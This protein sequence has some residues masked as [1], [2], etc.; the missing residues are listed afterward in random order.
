MGPADQHSV[1][2]VE[3]RPGELSFRARI[4]GLDK[5]LFVRST[6]TDLTPN[7][8]AA[9]AGCLMPA[10]APGGTLT[11]D[12]EVSPRLLRTQREFQAI[13]SAWS[14]GWEFDSPLLHEVEVIAPVRKVEPR[15][16]TGRVAAFFSGG[17]DSWSTVLDNPD[18]TDLIFVRGIDLLADAPNQVA[19]A[20][21][22]EARL[23]EAAEQIGLRLHSAETN[24]REL[25]DPLVRW[26]TC[27]ASPLAAVALFFAPL[28]DRVLI[29]GTTD[30]AS[31]Q[32]LGS[33]HLI[34]H[35]WSTE[36]TEIADDGGRYNRME[37]V[38]RIA[39]N[40]I[41]QRTLRV[42]WENPGGAYNCGHCIKC[43]LTMTALEALG[44]R[45]QVETFP[46]ELDLDAFAATPVPQLVSLGLREEILEAALESGNP[47]LVAS[48]E[49][50]VENGRKEL[51]LPDDYRRRAAEEAPSSR[52]AP[53]DQGISE[54]RTAPGELSFRARIGGL[55]ERLFIRSETAVTPNADA[56]LAACLLPAMRTGGSL[57]MS[58]PVSP[59]LLRTQREFQA[60][61]RAWSR[62]WEFGQPPLREVELR[63]PA[64]EVEGRRPT[65]R[66]A[67]FF[68]GGVDS[69][70][71][72]LDNPDVT[73]L[74]FVRGIDLLASA[75]HQLDLVEEVE[76]RLREAAGLLG[77][78]IHVVETN[79]RELSD[80]L[81]RWE[82]YFTS[83][84]AA[85]ALFFEPLFDRVLITGDT[86]YETQPRI[87][88]SWTVDSLWSTERVEVVDAGGPI[89]RVERTRRLAA[90]PVARRSLRVCWENPDGAYNCGRCRKCLITMATLEA[91]GVRDEFPTF[92]SELDPELLRAT[93]FNHKI[94]LVIWEDLLQAVRDAGRDDLAEPI[95]ESAAR[96][97]EELGLPPSHRFRHRSPA[98]VRG[99][100]AAATA[101][102]A[103]FGTPATAEA[104]AGARAVAF[105][106]GSYDGSGNFGDIA[107]LDAALALLEPLQPDLLVLPVIEHA[108]EADHLRAWEQMRHPGEHVLRFGAAAAAGNLVE[109]APPAGLAYAACYLY[110]GGYLNPDWGDRKLAM[111]GA[112][113]TLAIAGGAKRVDRLASGLQVDPDWVAGL[114]AAD[115]RTLRSFALLGGRER[116]STAALAALGGSGGVL[117]GGDDA[118]GLLAGLPAV[119]PADP[120][121][122]TLRVNV[123]FA[124][125]EWVTGD[126][127]AMLRFHAG[128]LAELGR[129]SERPLAVQPLLA[130]VDSRIDER[131]GLERLRGACA[132]AGAELLEPLL[133]RPVDLDSSAATIGRAELTLSCSYH[134]A[135]ASLMA[136]VPA[137]LVEDNP[138]YE[139]KAAGL[140]RD[141]ELPPELAVRSGEDPAAAAA[142]LLA[143]TT[144]ERGEA[145]RR[146]LRAG[147][148]A[149]TAR[150]RTVEAEVA[151]ILASGPL[152]V[153]AADGGDA[154]TRRRLAGAE[155]AVAAAERRA[156][157]A[158]QSAAAAHA[159]LG[160]VLGS[161]SWR[162]LEP[163]RRAARA[164]RGRG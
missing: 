93:A 27:F 99:N 103:L 164:A 71:T 82:T 91:I 125:H 160:E 72:V 50:L 120:D 7:A 132:E 68:S 77:L 96:G 95:A 115:Q 161:R 63:A 114:A 105:L 162:L 25:S 98:A 16:P 155:Q 126:P 122:A 59:R 87:G 135:L 134:A 145:R 149:V 21:E 142:R 62:D 51:S 159:R 86:D 29:A 67:A 53:L 140:R 73:D 151:S 129:R 15:R 12:A 92:P 152:G 17:V 130:Y 136:G 61:Q 24:L 158:E 33:S 74:I 116:R 31:Q 70:S 133:L 139:Q 57:T 3:R 144:G 154:A 13:Q 131:P 36:G 78:P 102:P 43:L 85:V 4:G 101:A 153:L 23:R 37:R 109:L 20:G 58:D 48:L 156:F 137:I 14:H 35:L 143:A 65:G 40:P 90:N 124:Q 66:V 60:I 18:L 148:A 84:L 100:P 112:V 42:C 94:A 97:R 41:V 64:R 141:F 8:D 34:D 119:E 89:D 54:L 32:P 46:P 79:V 83:P 163:L 6:T 2:E 118:I 5:R 75:P 26:E 146:R 80:P 52:L 108:H 38:R 157:D 106:V 123:H 147:G 47:D 76:A 81:V 117:D 19:I 55:D 11:I 121:P 150:R 30:Y 22:I 69:W 107:Q 88:P 45:E 110:G 111:L 128:F 39:A 9:L 10:M 28:F 44:A 56:A 138:Y 49:T 1:T 113:E 104:L 127:E